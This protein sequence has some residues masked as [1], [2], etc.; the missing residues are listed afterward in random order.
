VSG[1]TAVIAVADVGEAAKLGRRIVETLSG[2]GAGAVELM[3][4]AAV[5]LVA[6][7]KGAHPPLAGTAML[8]VDAE[9]TRA[10]EQLTA[11]L[12]Q[13]SEVR[14]LLLG[15]LSHE[16]AELRSWRTDLD[17]A[18]DATRCPRITA[19]S[20]SVSY[21]DIDR[22]VARV[23]RALLAAEPDLV[24]IVT[25]DLCSGVVRLEVARSSGDVGGSSDASH[26]ERLTGLISSVLADSFDHVATTVEGIVVRGDGRGRQ[27]G[28]PTANVDPL[29]TPDLP[30]DGV[31]AGW[32]ELQGGDVHVAAISVGRRPTYY[33]DGALLIEAH[34]LDFDGD[35]YGQRVVVEIG[36][37]VRGQA[38]FASVDELIHQ[39]AAD[40]ED[41]RAAVAGAEPGLG[42]RA[43]GQA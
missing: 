9:T 26:G 7:A 14:G 29:V 3:E 17:R 16:R 31:F 40:V 22:V 5:E 8:I 24:L 1:I 6:D 23:R 35:L 43:S 15:S 38:R 36:E 21:D 27:L 20:C 39:I 42:A 4:S 41:V 32:I 19:V 13:A 12:A 37:R 34:L 18:L 33:E 28:F 25:A 11:L 30:D 10:A 2:A